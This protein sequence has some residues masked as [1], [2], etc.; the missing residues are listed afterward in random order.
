MMTSYWRQSISWD[1]RCWLG[2]S[3]EWYYYRLWCFSYLH[4]FH[5]CRQ[6]NWSPKCQPHSVNNCWDHFLLMILFCMWSSGLWSHLAR[7]CASMALTVRIGWVLGCSCPSPLVSNCDH[8]LCC[9]RR[10]RWNWSVPVIDI[11]ANLRL[12]WLN[13]WPFLWIWSLS[14]DPLPVSDH[15]NLFLFENSIISRK[16]KISPNIYLAFLLQ[17]LRMIYSQALD[18]LQKLCCNCNAHEN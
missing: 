8:R 16:K 13:C 4:T 9:L 18:L 10:C 1:C 12:F 17:P 14:V 2:H 5:E 11:F 6:Q 7:M 3:E 15:E